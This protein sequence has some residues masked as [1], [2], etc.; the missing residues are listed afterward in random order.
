[1]PNVT[2]EEARLYDL[3]RLYS[4]IEKRKANIEI[5]EEAIQKERDSMER[6]RIMIGLLEANPD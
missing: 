6:E 2:L 3:D 1:M 5:F 4:L